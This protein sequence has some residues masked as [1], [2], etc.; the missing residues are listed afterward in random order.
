MGAQGLGSRIGMIDASLNGIL[1]FK[2]LFIMKKSHLFIAML[3]TFI[4]IFTNSTSGQ[5]I[6]TITEVNTF[7]NNNHFLVSYRE[8]ESVYGTYYFIDIH[9][10]ASGMYGLTGRSVKQTVM[11]NE[12][13]NNTDNCTL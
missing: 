12:Q 10:C 2:Y 1:N 9:Y 13:R 8:G 11:G 6:P 5:S 3:F 7:L 4:V